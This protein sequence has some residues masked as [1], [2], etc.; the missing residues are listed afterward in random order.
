MVGES[1]FF[2][3]RL[4]IARSWND[5]LKGVLSIS[6]CK[7]IDSSRLIEE[8]VEG[9]SDLIHKARIIVNR[10][11]SILIAEVYNLWYLLLVVLLLILSV[12]VGVYVVHVVVSLI[13]WSLL[14]L[15]ALVLI[16]RV[17]VLMI[18]LRLLGLTVSI[19][20]GLLLLSIS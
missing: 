5:H 16:L 9:L 19:L 12:V 2:I 11:H 13:S 8:V 15:V 14:G 18:V 10:L 1:S 20:R 17:G 6:W 3:I 4:V 7:L